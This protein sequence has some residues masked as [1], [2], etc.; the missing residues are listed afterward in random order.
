VGLDE[1][2]EQIRQRIAKRAPG[3]LGEPDTKATLIEPML[4]ALGWD[5]EDIDEV[6]REFKTQK[7]E[8][9]VDY[10]L[11]AE[12]KPVLFVEAKALGT[13]L[14]DPGCAHQIM[15]YVGVAGV[16]WIVLTDGDHYRLYNAHAP[17]PVE[18]KLLFS[19]AVSDAS[20][21]VVQRLGLLAKDCVTSG[22][23]TGAW[24]A[25][26]V[27]RQLIAGLQALVGPEPDDALV[28]LLSKRLPGL[29]SRQVRNG[30]RRLRLT[31]A[32]SEAQR[33]PGPTK[34]SGQTGKRGERVPAG[35]YRRVIL[36]YL[37]GQPAKAASSERIYAAV[38]ARLPP[39]GPD[40]DPDAKGVPKWRGRGTAGLSTLHRQGRVRRRDDG[41]WQLV[42]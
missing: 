36:E 14:D 41:L 34:R 31:V 29:T 3:S 13:N 11:L 20:Q 6:H 16:D 30:L 8:N 19:V 32:E 25:H 38:C 9:P 21:E 22:G 33:P 2:L 42:Q 37:A 28:S 23:L 26:F 18:G 15:G 10:A 7:R 40:L 1:A 27:D 5:P 4:R 39:V 12:G 24:E 35:E 17:V